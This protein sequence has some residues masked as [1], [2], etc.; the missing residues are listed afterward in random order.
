MTSPRSGQNQVE[1][2]KYDSF[3]IEYS[4]SLCWN[5]FSTL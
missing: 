2:F 1:F 5:I 4:Y 3:F